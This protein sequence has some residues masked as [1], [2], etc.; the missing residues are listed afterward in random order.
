MIM[1]GWN[2]AFRKVF[3]A[4][5]SRAQKEEEMEH[6]ASGLFPRLMGLV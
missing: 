3:P 2:K 6:V 4:G 1:M 5:R